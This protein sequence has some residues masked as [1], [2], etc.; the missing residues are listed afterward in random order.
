MRKSEKQLYIYYVDDIKT[1][2]INVESF[3]VQS[4]GDFYA[5]LGGRIPFIG[6]TVFASKDIGK[7]FWTPGHELWTVMKKKDYL[8]AKK[9]FIRK[10]VEE[11][12]EFKTAAFNRIEIAARL[13]KQSG[14]T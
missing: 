10:M 4:N 14:P 8:A 13:S 6:Y 5:I 1:G 3:P 2:K 12:T 11:A 9:M 7:V